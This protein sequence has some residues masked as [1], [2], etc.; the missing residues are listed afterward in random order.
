MSEK[1]NVATAFEA[2]RAT[3]RDLKKRAAEAAKLQGVLDDLR[4]DLERIGRRQRLFAELGDNHYERPQKS[5]HEG[6]GVVLDLTS[7]LSP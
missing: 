7:T 4:V 5:Y 6:L 1:G 2:Q 3:A